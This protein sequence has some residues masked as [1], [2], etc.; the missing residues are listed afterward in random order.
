MHPPPTSAREEDGKVMVVF[1]FSADEIKYRV[2]YF[3]SSPY[4]FWNPHLVVLVTRTSGAFS[5]RTRIHPHALPYR[6]M[7][8]TMI[9]R[10][11]GVG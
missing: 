6:A 2:A 10:I 7:I 4:S 3:I 1:H 9:R 8:D 11:W 5:V